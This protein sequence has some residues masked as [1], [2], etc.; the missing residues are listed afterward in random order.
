MDFGV[1][2]WLISGYLQYTSGN[3]LPYDCQTNVAK[4]QARIARV[5]FG[6]YSYASNL[7]KVP[8]VK[9]KEVMGKD[10]FHEVYKSRSD[11][12]SVGPHVKKELENL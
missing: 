10:K 5:Q 4:E 11:D 9:C 6:A 2:L 8:F 7:V 1:I 3:L 12:G